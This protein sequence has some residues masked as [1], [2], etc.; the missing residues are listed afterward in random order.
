MAST[1][2]VS[3]N[4]GLGHS[5]MGPLV[6][7]QGAKPPEAESFFVYFHA[8]KWPKLKYLNENLPQ[9]LRQDCFAQLLPRPAL[10]FGQW[11]GAAA[12]SA[13]SWIRH[14][15]PPQISKYATACTIVPDRRTQKTAA[16]LFYQWQFLA[17]MHLG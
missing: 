4:G 9:G 12:R 3:L 2:S 16:E 1:R 6:W 7:D 10:N 14:S 13:H 17:G 5:P 15:S 8:K 11:G